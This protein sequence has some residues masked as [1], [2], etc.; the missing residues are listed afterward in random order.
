MVAPLGSVNVMT[1]LVSVPV[2]VFLYVIQPS[3]VV[4]Y[5]FC[6]TEIEQ[7]DEFVDAANDEDCADLLPAA[8]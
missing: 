4:S 2:P 8:S 3:Y 7:L 1:G 6:V 5:V